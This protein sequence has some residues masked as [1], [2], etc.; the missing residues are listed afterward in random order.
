MG[1]EFFFKVL[2]MVEFT[3]VYQAPLTQ[4]ISCFLISHQPY[5]SARIL[6]GFIIG[7]YQYYNIL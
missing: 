5:N 3:G 6:L 7:F 1:I 2:T 4:V